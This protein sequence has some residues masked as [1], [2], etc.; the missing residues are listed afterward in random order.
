[1]LFAA[2]YIAVC[3]VW[4]VFDCHHGDRG[5]DFRREREEDL[6]FVAVDADAHAFFYIRRTDSLAELD[7]E[8][9]DLFDV[10]DIFALVVVLLV[11]YYLGAAGDLER[12]VFGHSLAIGG[13]VP[14]V[15]GCEA[16]V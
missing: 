2:A 6:V 13:N 9:G 16:C 7:D 1:M 12:V 15:R 3:D 5:I 10:D 11:L 14:E 4:L 8:F